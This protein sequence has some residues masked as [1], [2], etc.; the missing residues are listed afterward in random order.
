[1]VDPA[2]RGG[3][4]TRRLLH[5][6]AAPQVLRRLLRLDGDQCANAVCH[7]QPSQ[8]ILGSVL[9]TAAMSYMGYY[10]YD[11]YKDE[12]DDHNIEND[13]TLAYTFLVLCG[14]FGLFAFI[15]LCMVICL[16]KKI[17][18]AI[19]IV[20]EACEAVTSMP[21]IVLYPLCQYAAFLIFLAVWIVVAGYLAS[22]GTVSQSV[23]SNT[24]ATT[25][26]VSYDTEL[27]RAMCYHLFGLLW[28]T[29]FLRHFTIC[30]I[31]GAV[32]G[33]Y[34]TPYIDGDKKDLPLAPVVGSVWRT[35][36]YHQGTI[37]FGSFIIAVIEAIQLVIEYI[38][39]KY[40]DENACLKC[41]ASYIQ[42]CLECFKRIMEF[43][44][45]HAYIITACKGKNFCTAAWEAFNFILDNLTQIAAVNW[46]SMYLMF[47]G[48]V[49]IVLGTVVIC[50]ICAVTDDDISSVIVLLVVC[51]VIAYSV[52]CM[53]L[54]VFETGIDTILMCFMWEASAKGSFIGG[55]VY[56]TDH[57][58]C[59]IE[60]INVDAATDGDQRAAKEAFKEQQ[61]P[62]S[63]RKDES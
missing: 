60:G 29:A 25:Y 55:Y 57:L 39:R 15:L 50:Y 45:R 19:G 17:R 3:R 16:C 20:K 4:I 21:L 34:W 30:V 31:A 27:V 56:A 62:D 26:S 48:K 11:Y 28:T 58:N 5:L 59:F 9:I 6:G 23:D 2:C 7:P 46:I 18:I 53:F 52:A 37:A 13:R 12:Y 14:I 44:S 1:M 38:K 47:L 42:C 40:L 36:R 24:N 35:F 49:F 8:V 22:T 33:W 43:L 41:I 61:T 51:G 54:S 10:L 63:G 32:G